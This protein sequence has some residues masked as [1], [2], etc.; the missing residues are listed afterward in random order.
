MK[1]TLTTIFRLLIALLIGGL[2]TTVY[3][4][5]RELV[6]QQQADLVPEHPATAFGPHPTVPR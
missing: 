5:H 6:T 3:I 2:A 4:Q 1:Q